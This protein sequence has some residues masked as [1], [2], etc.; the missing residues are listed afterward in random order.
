MSHFAQASRLFDAEK[1]RLLASR[2]VTDAEKQH[3]RPYCLTFDP[4]PER[5]IG[6]CRYKC[7]EI[8]LSTKMLQCGLSDRMVTET[9][10]HE[11]SHAA[12]PGAKHGA[13]WRAFMA[14]AGATHI[15]SNCSKAKSRVLD[16]GITKKYLVYCPV[17][18]RTGKDGHFRTQRCKATARLK[19]GICPK[20][21]R[22]GVVSRL[23]IETQRG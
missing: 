19:R 12:T 17:G 9:I 1:S 13:A 3:I 23:V 11:L 18:G 5:R 14:K 15:G 21:K 20:C 8:G 22:G 2:K 4:K 16:K 10:R 6:Q 7:K